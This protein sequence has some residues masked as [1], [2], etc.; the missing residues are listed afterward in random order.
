[1]YTVVPVTDLELLLLV[2]ELA[3]LPNV[4]S[5]Q[6]DVF[7]PVVTMCVELLFVSLL[8]FPTSIL[9]SSESKSKISMLSESL[10]SNVSLL[11]E[12]RVTEVDMPASIAVECR[13]P[14]SDAGAILGGDSLLNSGEVIT[15]R[16]VDRSQCVANVFGF[17]YC[18]FHKN[19]FTFWAEVGPDMHWGKPTVVAFKESQGTLT[20]VKQIY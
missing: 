16:D 2:K 1:M 5:S 4:L 8:T 9:S 10:N 20:E 13:G 15:V 11:I 3:K 17:C 14:K 7:M 12:C 18:P 6:D 19:S